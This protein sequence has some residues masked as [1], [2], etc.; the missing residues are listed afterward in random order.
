M[1]VSMLTSQNSKLNLNV[2]HF[3]TTV[4]TGYNYFSE[5]LSDD[6][7]NWTSPSSAVS[8]LNKGAGMILT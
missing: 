1:H 5:G 7:A 2:G 4:T 8:G 3:L 6:W